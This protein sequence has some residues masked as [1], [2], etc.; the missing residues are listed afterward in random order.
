MRALMVLGASAVLSIGLMGV[1][2]PSAEAL[3]TGCR[4]AKLAEV[5][6]SDCSGGT[7]LHRARAVCKNGSVVYGAWAR[8]RVGSLAFCPNVGAD[9]VSSVSVELRD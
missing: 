2:S 5:G 7:G 8:V 3:P 6:I 4:T 9:S 1:A